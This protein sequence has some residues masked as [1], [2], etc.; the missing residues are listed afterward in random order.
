MND[1]ILERIYQKNDALP[2][3]LESSGAPEIIY[4]FLSIT[5]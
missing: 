3:A 2:S 1:N 4:D 5:I